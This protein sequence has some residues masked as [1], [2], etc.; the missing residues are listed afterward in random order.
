[1]MNN[2]RIS[3]DHFLI[4]V[5][6]QALAGIVYG[7]G[8]YMLVKRGFSSAMAGICLSLTNGFSLLIQPTVSNYLDNTRKV[9]VF[10]MMVL[11]SAIVTLLF[12]ANFFIESPGLL[13]GVVFVLGCGLYSSLEPLFNSLSNIFNRS[14]FNI[15]FGKDRACGSFSYGIVCAVFGVLSNNYSYKI[16]LLGGFVF[17]LFITFVTIQTRR[18]F[19][20][21]KVEVVKEE[22]L[23][24]MNLIE[25]IKDNN[26]YMILC[27]C[28]VGIFFGYTYADNFMLIIVE[29][30]GGTSKDM[31]LILGIKACLE[32]LMM[33]FYSKVRKHF[34]VETIL[35]IAVFAFA[36]KV[37]VVALATKITTIYLAQILQMACFAPIMPG[38]VEF[39]NNKMESKE[40]QRG[41]ACFTMT[42][43]FGGLLSSA[44]GG[45]LTDVIGIKPMEFIAFATILV[46]AIIFTRVVDKVR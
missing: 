9:T 28:L 30:V 16:V 3:I 18:D 1:M 14:G 5:S 43:C 41:H 26:I 25:F 8:I 20:K 38:M 35:K 21:C 45:V 42:I 11:V 6:F 4:H 12:L 37:L 46:C 33:I 44:I 19:K 34:K 27:I 40:A 39:V 23:E 22:K 31:G 32:G 36:L 17:A 13:L 2:K 24:K 10:E 15:D 7:F 29:S